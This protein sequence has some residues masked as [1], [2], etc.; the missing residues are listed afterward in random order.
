VDGNPKRILPSL[1]PGLT[2]PIFV[3][4]LTAVDDPNNMEVLRTLG[5]L[6]AE[7]LVRSADFIS[8]FDLPVG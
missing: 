8:N 4:H 3:E 1:E 7:R 2:D 6:A 5:A